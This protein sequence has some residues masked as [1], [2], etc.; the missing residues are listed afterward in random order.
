[1]AA[2][3]RRLP[4][5]TVPALLLLVGVLL[6]APSLALPPGPEDAVLATAAEDLAGE[7]AA[8]FRGHGLL[9]PLLLVVPTSAGAPAA[10]ALRV[11]GLLLGALAPLLTLALARRLGF[12]ER[13]AALCALLL[14]VHPVLIA[15]AG[16][17]EAGSQGLALVLLL[18]AWLRLTRPTPAGGRGG[19][20]GTR[21]E[22]GA[23][24]VGVLASLAWPA[25]WPYLLAVGVLALK[26]ERSGRA[27]AVVGVVAVA[28]IAFSVPRGHGEA[29]GP[30][31]FLLLALPIL[32]LVILLPFVVLGAVRMT[33]KA[34][35]GAGPL[36][37]WGAATDVHALLLLAGLVRPGARL[38]WEAAQAT[39][40]LAPLVVFAAVAGLA[41]LERA[42][43]LRVE[44]AALALAVTGSL[45]L[46][47][48]PA[49]AALFGEDAGL[50]GRLHVLGTAARLADREAGPDGWLALDLGE[51]TDAEA[52]ALASWLG[53]RKVLVTPS[54]GGPAQP[55]S[56]WPEGGPRRMA[57]LTRYPEPGDITTLGG[58][59]IFGQTPAGRSGP[60]H[61]LRIRRP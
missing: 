3:A 18:A 19:R 15:H 51:G 35:G 37:A 45:L 49:Q 48:G 59:G 52:R 6:R 11:V 17:P 13:A 16:G 28:A 44:A 7:R 30:A 53:G 57:L 41:R 24:A 29:G 33:R 46:G 5:G 2:P 31:G 40:L 47:L 56:G 34:N 14:A 43:R 50:A 22:R 60:W 32:A 8:D 39:V 27:R 38:G 25:A 61:V 1:M 26:A 9:L 58:Y 12:P 21:T 55:P 54:S 4:R 23:L 42:W 20:G 36:L 10:V